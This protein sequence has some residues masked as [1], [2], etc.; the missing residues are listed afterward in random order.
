[1]PLSCISETTGTIP[2]KLV[3]LDLKV[4]SEFNFGSYW[5]AI[6][7]VLYEAENEFHCFLRN[8][9]VKYL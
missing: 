4:L 7:P 8:C 6:N 2:M 5:P 3:I 9:C 1:M